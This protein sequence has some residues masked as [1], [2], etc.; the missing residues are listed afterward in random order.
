MLNGGS[1]EVVDKRVAGQGQDVWK[2]RCYVIQPCPAEVKRVVVFWSDASR[3][4]WLMQQ[5]C[6]GYDLAWVP[7]GLVAQ[8]CHA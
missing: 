6:S 8:L 1:A 2:Y 7:V 5:L 4:D 3:V